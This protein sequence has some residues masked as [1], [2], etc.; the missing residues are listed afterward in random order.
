MQFDV[1]R[2]PLIEICELEDVQLFEWNESEFS[3]STTVKPHD[4][5]N[6]DIS[7]EIDLAAE[8]E[9]NNK[10]SG[11]IERKNAAQRDGEVSKLGINTTIENLDIYDDNF[12]VPFAGPWQIR[13]LQKNSHVGDVTAN[14]LVPKDDF[15]NVSGHKSPIP[16]INKILSDETNNFNIIHRSPLSYKMSRFVITIR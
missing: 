9:M 8:N 14:L 13:D 11:E 16:A 3:D 2:P 12:G 6:F 7:H 15:I 10:N 5:K 1:D 4:F